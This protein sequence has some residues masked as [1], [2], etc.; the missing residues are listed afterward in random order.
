LVFAEDVSEK[1]VVLPLAAAGF[2]DV[3]VYCADVRFGLL[4]KEVIA[5]PTYV[6]A[7]DI[8]DVSESLRNILH[9][10]QRVYCDG[11]VK[12]RLGR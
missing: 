11:D 3:H 1:K 5:V 4:D 12:D 9:K 7:I 6:A 2:D 8:A 10:V